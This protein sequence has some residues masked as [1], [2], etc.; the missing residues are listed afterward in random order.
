MD[1]N[2]AR[3][4]FSFP[5]DIRNWE[6]GIILR[7]LFSALSIKNKTKLSKRFVNTL[8]KLFMQEQEYEGF[9]KV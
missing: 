9:Q 8:D 1:K 4:I 7:K 2:N 5:K 3:K 6:F